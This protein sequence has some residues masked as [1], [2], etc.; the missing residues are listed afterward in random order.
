MRGKI[1]LPLWQILLHWI[2]IVGYF[3]ILQERICHHIC[4]ILPSPS[5][6]LTDCNIKRLN[7][8]SIIMSM[9]TKLVSIENIFFL[10]NITSWPHSKNTFRISKECF[11]R[12]LW[13]A[14][15]DPKPLFEI[16]G[17]RLNVIIGYITN[18]TTTHIAIS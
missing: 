7:S 16:S 5:Q 15:F 14:L 10:T 3:I 11:M 1:K 9:D 4:S 17:I 2:F 13:H 6:M 8:I 12:P 18:F